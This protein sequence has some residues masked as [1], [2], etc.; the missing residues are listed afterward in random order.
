MNNRDYFLLIMSAILY[1]LPFL[2][3]NNFWFLIFFFPVPLLYIIRTTIFLFIHGFVWGCITFFL[4]F[5][6]GIYVLATMAHEW[7][8][9]GAALGIAMVLY[10]ALFVAIFFWC[11]TYVVRTFL[12]QSPCL[13]L[14]IWLIVL[15]FF[16]VWVD[17]YSLWVFGVQEGYPLMHPLILLVQRPVLLWLLPVV[18][19]QLLTMLFLL[20]PSSIVLLLW[21]KNCWTL[22]FLCSVLAPWFLYWEVEEQKKALWYE[23]IKSL[24]CMIYSAAKNHV[25][26]TK[27]IGNHLK[28]IIDEY[29]ET[30]IIIMPESACNIDNC[31]DIPELMC[32][33]NGEHI[34]K[35]IHIIFGASRYADSNYYNSLH[36]VYD[37]VLQDCFDK[38]HGMLISERL[39]FWM[40]NDALRN[41]YFTVTPPIAISCCLRKNIQI[42]SE[43][44][45]PY[46]CSELFFNEF[47]DDNGGDAPIIAVINDSLFLDNFY[48][49][50]IQQLLVCV[51][52]FKA[53]QWQRTIIYVSYAQ[54]LFIDQQGRC[55]SMNE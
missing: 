35:P 33:W 39:P 44:F 19:K 20:V 11:A 54:S 46:I 43:L 15:Y 37:G 28:K 36:W 32:L 50:Y 5:S 6:G 25:V 26:A 9:V 40:N 3:S 41:I 1:A 48:S 16:M 17:R 51:A 42:V 18:G 45:V 30:E 55:I 38:R 47:P 34:G 52:R 29:P 49:L 14:F 2:L 22:F 4:H 21:Y 13:R 10:Y 23:Q 12:I 7:W 27:I 53:T 24:P 8:Y 31:A